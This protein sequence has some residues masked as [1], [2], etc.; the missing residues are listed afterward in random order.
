MN[1]QPYVYNLIKYTTYAICLSMNNPTY[2]TYMLKYGH[3]YVY[4]LRNC[5]LFTYSKRC[6]YRYEQ[7]HGLTTILIHRHTHT[8][9]HQ[10]RAH[11]HTNTNIQAYGH[12]DI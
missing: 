11:T 4:Y 10:I 3:P 1:E 12:T 5:P 6:T 7:V 2:T 8:Q 9:T